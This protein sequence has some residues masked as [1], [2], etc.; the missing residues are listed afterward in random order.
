[1][2]I[3]YKIY[4]SVLAERLREKAERK[5]ILPKNQTRFRKG[6]GTL[7]SIYVLNYLINRQIGKE[8]GGEIGGII[9]RPK[10]SI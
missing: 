4:V 5:R 1:M 6:M 3:L 9:C 10:G 2:S 7:D 8:E